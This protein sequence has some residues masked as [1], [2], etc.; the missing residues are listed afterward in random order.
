MTSADSEIYY[1]VA[2][3]LLA[4]SLNLEEDLRRLD[5]QLDIANSA[6]RYWYGGRAWGQSF[7]QTLSDSFEAGSLAAMAAC[8]LG[9]QV[10]TAG[11]NLDRSENN[12]HPGS[13]VPVPDTPR[14]TTLVRNL[15]PT[16][17]SIG[18][19]EGD[20]D[21]WDLVKDLVTKPWAD[22]DEGR[23]ATTGTKLSE[24]GTKESAFAN[25][26]YLDI[27]ALCTDAVRDE[28]KI[29][30]EYVGD[31]VHVCRA[32]A[33]SAD[34][35]QYLA[36]ACTQV[37]EFIT[38]AKDDCRTSLGLLWGIVGSYELDKI[39]ARRLPK[40]DALVRELDELIKSNK[41][42]YAA[43]IS[44]RLGE[45]EPK[46]SDAVASNGAIYNLV[47][48][49]TKGLSEII[50]RTP[51]STKYISEG[52]RSVSNKEAGDE[53]ERRAGYDPK[54][55]KRKITIIDNSGNP[56]ISYP[57]HID[58]ENRQLIE[59]KNTNDIAGNTQQLQIQEQWA[60]D[61]GYTMVLIVDHRTVINDPVIQG[62]IDTGQIQLIRK[63]LD[64]L[65]YPP[66]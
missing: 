57:D 24:F 55:H 33:A 66:P 53:G 8:E 54:S 4:A 36:I 58:E 9:K 49:Q 25:R 22:C 1:G 38:A 46:V 50:G 48:D 37:A 20:P 61:N 31:A 28:D 44:A 6:G 30:D 63:E 16:E 45:I 11:Q 59:V 40:G 5:K 62:Y 10:H 13:P 14:G 21:R 18:S 39:A 2:D 27:T 26:L 47:T 60:R 52:D 42:T 64:T 23:I 65:D 3:K 35:A 7:D 41:E 32:I 51:R 12:S 15:R 43:A 19:G 29:L 34:A 17:F 56:H